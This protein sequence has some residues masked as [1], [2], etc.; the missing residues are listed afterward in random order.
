MLKKTM[1]GTLVLGLT[2]LAFATGVQATPVAN[3]SLGLS[4]PSNVIDFG[5]NLFPNLT[6][7]TDQFSS[8]GVTFGSNYNYYDFGA[9]LPSW[10]SLQHGFLEAADPSLQP[11]YMLFSS[12][13]SAA[14]FNFYTNNG[15]TT[16]SAYLE[17]QLIETF[18]A[19]TFA[20]AASAPARFYG[21]TD[22]TFDKITF[23]IQGAFNASFAI[24]NLQFV[25]ESTS[26]PEPG[27]LA[28]LGLGI[29]GLASARRRNKNASH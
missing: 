4:A 21:F 27:T 2:G 16:F 6:P 20:T 14:V 23:S 26:V 10:Q 29:A 18:S 5:S 1:R 24:D 7:I 9:S 28:L 3:S 12:P 13:V 11:G 25:T 15:T 8:Q 19:G 17:N 22:I